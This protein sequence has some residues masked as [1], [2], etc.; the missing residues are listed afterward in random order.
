MLG[1]HV[2]FVLLSVMLEVGG[3][4]LF[5]LE[6]ETL[7]LSLYQ[8]PWLKRDLAF[9]NKNYYENVYDPP[10]PRFSFS[11]QSLSVSVS[12]GTNL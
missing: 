3:Y 4:D 8:Q 9:R 1:V 2:L 7:P 12:S 10:P 6:F 5:P 11:I